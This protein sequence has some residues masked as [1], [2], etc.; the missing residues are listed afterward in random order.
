LFNNLI[1]NAVKFTPKDGGVITIDAKKDRDFVTISVKD[2]GIGIT[3]EQLGRIFDEF[4]RA[5]KSMNVMDSTGLGLSI[6]KR[7]VEKHGGRIWAES[8]GKGK[9]TTFYFTLKLLM[10][11]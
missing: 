6:C 10:E 2:S 1:T 9:G 8:P 5:D 7:I 3:E 4:Y 11:N